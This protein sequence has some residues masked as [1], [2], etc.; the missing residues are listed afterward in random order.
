MIEGTTTKG[1]RK[2]GTVAQE[3]QHNKRHNKLAQQRK[4]HTM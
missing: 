3:K 2:Q 1:K 4:D